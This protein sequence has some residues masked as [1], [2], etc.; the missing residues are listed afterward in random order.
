MWNEALNLVGVEA[1]STLRRVENVYYPLAIWA[2][3]SLVSQDDVAPKD[4]SSI[5]EILAKDL[6]PP[7]SPLKGAEQASVAEK[8]KENPKEVT[9]ET[10]K[11]PAAP[12][13]SSKGGVVSQSHELVLTTFPILAKEECKGK[14]PASSTVATA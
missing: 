11:P 2:L 5:D 12:K 7:S 13:D 4:P 14:G 1:S 6:P 3:G 8:E 9:F 10:T